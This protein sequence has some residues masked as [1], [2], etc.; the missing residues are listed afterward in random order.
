MKGTLGGQMSVYADYL[1]FRGVGIHKPELRSYEI[2]KEEIGQIY[3]L[4]V[5]EVPRLL[6]ILPIRRYGIRV[7]SEPGGAYKERD[8][9]IFRFD[10]PELYEVLTT[11]R[12][13]GYPIAE[14]TGG[15]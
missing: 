5:T 13:A 9:Y 6:R 7:V 3:P 10:A 15:A 2:R 11:M 4:P 1:R 8:E 12:A 14:T